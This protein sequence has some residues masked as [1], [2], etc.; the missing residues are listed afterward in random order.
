MPLVAPRVDFLWIIKVCCSSMPTWCPS[1]DASPPLEH[2]QYS[3][4]H[5]WSSTTPLNMFEDHQRLTHW[6]TGARLCVAPSP[7]HTTLLGFI[8]TRVDLVIIQDI[9]KARITFWVAHISIHIWQ[10]ATGRPLL[11]LLATRGVKGS[12]VLCWPILESLLHCL[13]LSRSKYY[14]KWYIVHPIPSCG[15]N[16]THINVVINV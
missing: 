8:S 5:M 1:V 15:V 12:L 13:Q 9:T 7:R 4:C 16:A 14:F 2:Q 10:Y 6:A 11:L 3:N